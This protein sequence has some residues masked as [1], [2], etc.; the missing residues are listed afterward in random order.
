M[1][2]TIANYIDMHYLTPKYAMHSGC[3]VAPAA[4]A[5]SAEGSQG[6]LCF[7]RGAAAADLPVTTTFFLFITLLKSK[8]CFKVFHLFII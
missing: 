5:D 1:P 8:I 4:Q 2:I 6:T 3:C 7:E